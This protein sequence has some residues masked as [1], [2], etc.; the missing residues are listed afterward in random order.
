MAPD[1]RIY[2]IGGAHSDAVETLQV[3]AAAGRE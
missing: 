3:P 1:G 2:A